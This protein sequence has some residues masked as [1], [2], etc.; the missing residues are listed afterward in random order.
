MKTVPFSR[1]NLVERIREVC[2][3]PDIPDKED[4]IHHMANVF[5]M[6]QTFLKGQGVLITLPDKVAVFNIKTKLHDIEPFKP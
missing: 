5:L 1:E 4:F 2:P 3:I 6:N